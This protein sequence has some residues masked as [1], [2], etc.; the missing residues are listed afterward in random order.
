MFIPGNV[1]TKATLTW[2][3]CIVDEFVIADCAPPYNVGAVLSKATARGGVHTPRTRRPALLNTLIWGKMFGTKNNINS[4][5]M[6]YDEEAT[7]WG[8]GEGA[9]D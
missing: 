3:L 8:G 2:F 1:M 6:K 5:S 7:R 4:L 9:S